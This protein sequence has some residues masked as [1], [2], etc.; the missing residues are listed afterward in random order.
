MTSS[1]SFAH[2]ASVLDSI[3]AL[4]ALLSAALA[5]NDVP[6]MTSLLSRW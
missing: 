5:A 4:K 1:A 3:Y 6:T 2:L